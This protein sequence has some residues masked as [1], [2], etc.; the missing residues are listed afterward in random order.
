MYSSPG[1]AVDTSDFV[2]AINML[3]HSMICVK[4]VY[5]TPYHMVNASDFMYGIYMCVHLVVNA[6]LWHMSN[7]ED[8]L[9]FVRYKARTV[10]LVA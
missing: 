10:F 1:H 5:S 8:I 4:Y 9:V 3:T 7:L 6:S 2:C